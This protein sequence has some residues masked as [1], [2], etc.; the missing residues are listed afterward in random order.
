MENP[1]LTTVTPTLIA[2]DRSNVDV[3][4]HEASHSWSGNLV[5]N[6][7]WE[8][9]WLNEGWTVFL[10][11]KITGRMHGEEFA[12]FSAILGWK[13]LKDA[14]DQFGSDDDGFTQLVT[15]LD[16]KDPDDAFSSVPYEK[17]FN[18]LF[19]LEGLV[20]IKNFENFFK[21]YIQKHRFQCV[22]SEQFK[23]FFLNYFSN[24]NGISDLSQIDWKTWFTKPGMP[25][26][27]PKFDTTLSTVTQELAEK[28]ITKQYD[29]TNIQD[30]TSGQIVVFLDRFLASP[31]P[32]SVELLQKLDQ[33][34]KFTQSKNAEIRFRWYQLCI[35][36]DHEEVFSH[37][38]N[39]LKEQGRMKYVRPLYRS[40][41]KS[42]KGKQL[43]VNTFMESRSSYHNIASKMI[44]KD[45]EI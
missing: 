39:F 11:R 18:F 35:R 22:T 30:W 32:L 34:Y 14:I 43:A 25:V 38:V 12:E 28:W 36:S 41:Y 45:L 20:G 27:E 9:F 10:E 6:A 21:D 19:Y 33:S 2:G 5:T 37:V 16:G 42:K 3:V 44:A 13:S 29:A 31:D 23:E 15:K 8:D 26:I 7:T 17:G 1:N 4:A 24:V 40:L